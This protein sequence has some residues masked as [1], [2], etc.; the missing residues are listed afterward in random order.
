MR[1]WTAHVESTYKRE[2][3]KA[4]GTQFR[5]LRLYRECALAVGGRSYDFASCLPVHS[6]HINRNRSNRSDS[7]CEPSENTFY[8]YI[9]TAVNISHRTKSLGKRHALRKNLAPLPLADVSDTLP[10][11]SSTAGH[12][13][14]PCLD[15]DMGVG[16]S[17]LGLRRRRGRSG[18]KAPFTGR[19]RPK[20]ALSTRRRKQDTRMGSKVLPL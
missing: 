8:M 7:I 2:N 11:S 3:T 4:H 9:G 10:S 13:L 15:T 6:L 17:A 12:Y 20:Q 5:L 14:R 18:E 16:R 19:R 1:G